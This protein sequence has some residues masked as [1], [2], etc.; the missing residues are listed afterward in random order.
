MRVIGVDLETTGL[1]IAKDRIL[2]IGAVIYDTAEKIPLAMLS[3][4]IRPGPDVEFNEG[5][6]S[7]TGLKRA[8]IEEFGESLVLTLQHVELMIE[9]HKPEA[10][11]GHN[12]VGYDLPMLKHEADRLGLNLPLLFGLPVIDTRHDLPFEKEPS[13][14]RLSH[15]IADHNFLNPYPHRAVFD[16]MACLKLLSCYDFQEVFAMSKIPFVTMRAKV[17]YDDRQKAKDLRYSW[18]EAGGVKYPKWW[19]KQVRS[20]A[21]EREVAMCATLGFEAE[22]VS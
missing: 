21:V 1:D 5:Y 19:V 10:I 15:L 14:R 18:E 7:P 3:E 6:V 11:V 13:S 2:E 12:I 16:V 22:L 20:N 9:R 4:I 17:S 8:H